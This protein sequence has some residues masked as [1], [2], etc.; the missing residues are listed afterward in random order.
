VTSN[1]GDET[2]AVDATMSRMKISSSAVVVSLSLSVAF[3]SSSL[4]APADPRAGF[5]LV[6]N[7]QSA[8]VSLIDLKTDTAK[9]IAVGQGP[10]ET[11]IAPSGRV[12]VVTIYG[13]GGAPGNGLAVIDIAQ[14]AV[15]KTISLGQYTRPH[16]ANFF[17][18]DET[19]VAVT[20]EAT[21][22]VVVVNLTEGKVEYA[23]PTGAAGSHM[24]GLIANGTRA[25]TSNIGGGSVS[26]LDV[27]GKSTVRTIAVAP[28]VEGI[29]VTPDGSAVWAGSNTNGTVSIIDT[30]TGTI[31]E[32][33]TGFKLPYR[34]AMSHDGKTA[35]IC[36]PEGDA[37]HVADVTQRKVLWKLEGLGSPRGVN[38]AP[39][40]KTAFVTLAADETMG[41]VDLE[42]RKLTRRVKVEKSPDGVWYGPVPR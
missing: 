22:N 36:D 19:R 10:H 4:A 24:V 20:S 12:A 2:R 16:G 41:V 27:A 8:S 39:D 37:I 18:G 30:K 32:T 34:L 40:G 1:D 21:Q 11:V 29:A 3:A 5:V 14:G 23:I 26:E 33:L 42:A 35:I 15:T 31:V 7:Q 9:V 25:F 6:A 28:R 13:I 38:I 17:P